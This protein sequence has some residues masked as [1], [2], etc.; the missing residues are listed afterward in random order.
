MHY[1][2]ST[3]YKIPIRI[4]MDAFGSGQI[5]SDRGGSIRIGVDEIDKWHTGTMASCEARPHK[6]NEHT[7]FTEMCSVL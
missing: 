3:K 6:K 4:G 1:D 5:H 2:F 7:S